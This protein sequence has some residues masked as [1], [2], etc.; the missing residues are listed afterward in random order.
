MQKSDANPQ[1]GFGEIV[2][3]YVEMNVVHPVRDTEIR[4]LLRAALT[5]RTEDR[6]QFLKGL[7]RSCAYEGYAAFRAGDL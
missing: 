5:D 6:E 1:S 3:K 4:E 2:E 7:D